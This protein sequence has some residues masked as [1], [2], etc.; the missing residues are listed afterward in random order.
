MPEAPIEQYREEAE[1]LAQLPRQ[2]QREIIAMHR[3]IARNPKVPKRDRE[4]GLERA[5]ALEHLLRLARKSKTR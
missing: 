1:R 5:D 4:A 3:D 2:D